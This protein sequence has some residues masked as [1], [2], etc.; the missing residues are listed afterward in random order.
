MQTC[1]DVDDG[2]SGY[3]TMDKDFKP[4]GE[5]PP[6]SPEANCV[7]CKKR[8]WTHGDDTQRPKR[9]LTQ[10]QPAD[11]SLACLIEMGHI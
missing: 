7:L 10:T 8:F 3:I 2:A 6:D 4:T 9:A 1:A 11:V 5:P